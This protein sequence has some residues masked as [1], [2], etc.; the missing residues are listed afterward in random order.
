MALVSRPAGRWT[1]AA[2]VTLAY[3]VFVIYL[4]WPTTTGFI[5]YDRTGVG[6]LLTGLLLGSPALAGAALSPTGG[7]SRRAGQA[8]FGLVAL[9]TLGGWLLVLVHAQG[10]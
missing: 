1:L 6:L 10:P 5:H 3:A 8:A 7:L 9:S 2:L 4:P